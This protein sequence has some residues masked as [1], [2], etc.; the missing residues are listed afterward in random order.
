MK[1]FLHCLFFLFSTSAFGQVQ[2]DSIISYNLISGEPDERI[3]FQYNSDNLLEQYV[4]SEAI[5]NID[6][7]ENDQFDKI[8]V[9]SLDGYYEDIYWFFKYNTENKLD[10]FIMDYSSIPGYDYRDIFDFNYTGDVLE[11]IVISYSDNGYSYID[12]KEKYEFINGNI[13]EINYYQI[14]GMYEYLNRYKIYEYSS[15]EK[16][17]LIEYYGDDDNIQR[18]DSFGYNNVGS[19]ETFYYKSFYDGELDFEY[20]IN[21]NTMNGESYDEIINPN[22]FFSLNLF[23]NYSS[24]EPFYY[25]FNLSNKV[26]SHQIN[27]LEDVVYTWYYS[28]MTGIN[29]ERKV[30]SPISVY[31]NPTTE[32]LYMD[33]E[34]DIKSAKIF[35]QNGDLIEEIIDFQENMIYVEHLSPANYTIIVQDVNGAFYVSFFLKI[36]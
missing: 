19:H 4:D 11:E 17:K 5:F 21:Y 34:T 9:A 13:S 10:S 30:A 7:N 35:G 32:F 8:Q 16:L 27:Y 3:L 25:V 36:E 1:H 22:D 23:L 33:I 28:V 31:P 24:F 20:S 18:K 29:D 6:Y 12:S 26:Q 2:L 15:N 14:D